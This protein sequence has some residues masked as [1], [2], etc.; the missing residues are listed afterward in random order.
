MK[1]G[2]VLILY[3]FVTSFL[4]YFIFRIIFVLGIRAQI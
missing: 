4:V 1:L 3:L 2:H